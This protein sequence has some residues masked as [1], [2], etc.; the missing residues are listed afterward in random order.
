M[1]DKR[2]FKIGDLVV[3]KNHGIGV[4]NISDGDWINITYESWFT[5]INY[6]SNTDDIKTIRNPR[7]GSQEARDIVAM[8]GWQA[9]IATR[10]QAREL[11]WKFLKDFNRNGGIKN[12]GVVVFEK[13]KEML[14]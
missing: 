10:L 14:K 9:C 6:H 2:D 1:S 3:S 7:K 11:G 13:A 4:I 5:D 8:L 12:Y